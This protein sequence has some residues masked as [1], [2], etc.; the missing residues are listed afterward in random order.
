MPF[1]YG[2]T[3]PSID[4]LIDEAKEQIHDHLESV[5]LENNPYVLSHDIP[6]SLKEHIKDVSD[7]LYEALEDVFEGCRSINEE[8]RD[9]AD[10][11]VNELEEQVENLEAEVADDDW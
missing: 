4:K 3:C 5:V 1:D 10:K 6:Q 11:Q 2:Y 9:A 7:A 8:M